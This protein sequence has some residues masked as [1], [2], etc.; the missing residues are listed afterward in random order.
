ML[1]GSR[2]RV[3]PEV[4][5]AVHTPPSPPSRPTVPLSVSTLLTHARNEPRL[6]AEIASEIESADAVDMLV[7]F[8]KWHGWRRL[9]DA[10]E[11]FARA[12]KKLRV[13]T[14]TYMGATD[15]EALDAIARLPG[16]EVR[17]SYD[18]RRTRLH[19]K[20]WLFHR[21]TRVQLRV[22][23]LLQPLGRGAVGG[24]RVERSRPARPSRAPSSRSSGARSS[25]SGRTASSSRTTRTRPTRRGDSRRRCPPSAAKRR[26]RRRSSSTCGPTNSSSAILEKLRVEREEH[27]RWKNLVVAATGTG[28]TIIAAFDYARPGQRR[29]SAPPA[30]RRAPGGD[31]RAGA[32]RVPERPARPATSASS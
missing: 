20:A 11:V 29:S 30:L 1:A 18:A 16:A 14:T 25:R 23:R 12:G 5:L 13:L 22:R 10:F 8:I 7:S 3:P 19:A 26:G 28:K 21:A 17:V 31:P 9:K 24:A 4:L 15:R 32:A 27:R 2:L 6:G